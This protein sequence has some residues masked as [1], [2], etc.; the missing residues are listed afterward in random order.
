M[1][2]IKI[3]QDRPLEMVEIV[4]SSKIDNINRKYKKKRRKN[5]N[6]QLYFSF[7]HTVY[8]I[9]LWAIFFAS[10]SIGFLVH[11]DTIKNVTASSIL[12]TFSLILLFFCI[13]YSYNYYR[14][15]KAKTE[16]ELQ[17]YLKYFP[18]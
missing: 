3:D 13:L 2:E 6:E 15:T 14:C 8:L 5:L 16:E 18:C 10:F 12:W 1:N 9:T 11:F 7:K 4:D 17:K